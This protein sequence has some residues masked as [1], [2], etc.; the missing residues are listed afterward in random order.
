MKPWD[1]TTMGGTGN[2]F[3]TTQ[4]SRILNAKTQNETRR[5]MILNNLTETYWK[6]AYCYLRSKGFE[7]DAAKDLTQDFFLKIVLGRD[8]IQKADQ[9]KG[10]FRSFLLVALERYVVSTLRYEGRIKRGGNANVIHMETPDLANLD[11]HESAPDP[12]HAF[13]YAWVSTLLDQVLAD[14]KEEYCSTQRAGHWEVFRLR[15]LAPIFENTKEP[16][17]KEICGKCNIADES[18]VANMIVTVKR[19]FR[20]VLKRNLRNLARTDAEA[21]EEFAEIFR[22]LSQ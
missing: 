7:N 13:C 16:S 12:N 11:I 3:M 2:Q 15:V 6:P 1:N 18:K 8:L 19:R 10:R 22:I 4:W 9:S 21:D 17:Y 5:R 14:I 20:S